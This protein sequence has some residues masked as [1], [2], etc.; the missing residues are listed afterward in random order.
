LNPFR[1]FIFYR[2]IVGSREN[3]IK[4]VLLFFFVVY[5]FCF[6]AASV[7]SLLFIKGEPYGLIEDIAFFANI[8]MNFFLIIYTAQ[9]PKLFVDTFKGTEEKFNY[10][11]G[12]FNSISFNKKDYDEKSYENDF[13]RY[14]NLIMAE[15]KVSK[16][17]LVVLIVCGALANII[18]EIGIYN[19]EIKSWAF[20]SDYTLT[21]IAQ[22]ITNFCQYWF[23]YPETIFLMVM[24]VFALVRIVREFS[25]HNVIVLTPVVKDEKGGLTPITQLCFHMV[26]ILFFPLLFIFSFMIQ[27]GFMLPL[28]FGLFIYVLLMVLTFVLPLA[29]IHWSMEEYKEKELLNIERLYKI[30]QVKYQEIIR[31]KNDS[32]EEV[33]GLVREMVDINNLFILTKKLP[34]WPYDFKIFTRFFSIIIIPIIVLFVQLVTNADSILFNLEK[35]KIFK[36]ILG[37]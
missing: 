2:F 34:D 37:F 31:K 21:F 36:N 1:N 18:T 7:D 35:L 12:I 20:Q 30:C 32:V 8:I 29:Y 15:S 28:F 13:E 5:G 24:T 23:I 10:A 25:K 14:S 6:V 19:G 11:E 4:R 16:V 27:L 22:L 26:K 33:I 17:I 3:R 9:L